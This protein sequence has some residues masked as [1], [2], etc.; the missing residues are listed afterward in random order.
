M[1]MNLL[2]RGLRPGARFLRLSHG[3]NA[4]LLECRQ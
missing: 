2:Y 1:F 4:V 3:E